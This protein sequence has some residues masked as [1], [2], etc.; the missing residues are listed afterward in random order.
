MSLKELLKVGGVVVEVK[1]YYKG[2][3]D[4]IAGEGIIL[5]EFIGEVATRQINI[6][7]GDYYASS[8]LLDKNDKIGFLLYDGKKSDLDLSEAEEISNDEFEAIWERSTVSL[9]EKKRIN[10]LSGDA[11][12]PLKKSTVIAHIVNNK[13]KW[14]KGFVLSLSN[15]YP[16]AKK[17]YLSRFKEN[18]IPELGMI[19][20]VK[21]DDQEQIFIANMYA[22]DG[23]KKNINDKKQYVCY[24]SLDVCLEKLSDFALAH[25]L[26]IQMPR[27]GAGLGGGDWNVIEALIL[28]KICYKM[29][30][31]NVITL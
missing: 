31:C 15:K 2:S 28:K 18:N 22:Q 1:K 7:N 27:I 8:S 9:Q 3:V 25:R 11:V 4:F 10:Y 30:D 23:I 13:G 21:V 16:A 6:I 17:H 12:E 19:D 29:I 20:F 26:S 5:N 24:Q 14:G